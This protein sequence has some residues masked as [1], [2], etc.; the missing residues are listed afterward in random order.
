MS[1]TNYYMYSG[2]PLL[3]TTWGPDE[4]NIW[5]DIHSGTLLLWTPSEVS[6][7]CIERDPHFRGKFVLRNIWDTEKCL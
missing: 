7:T 2:A 6:C 3:W 5:G 4:P 1:C